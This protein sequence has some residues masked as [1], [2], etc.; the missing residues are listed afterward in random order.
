MLHCTKLAEK[1]CTIRC[2]EEKQIWCK[3][4]VIMGW[5]TKW[6]ALTLQG[7]PTLWLKFTK[8]CQFQMVY[9]H[10]VQN[11]SHCSVAHCAHACVL[12]LMPPFCHSVWFWSCPDRFTGMLGTWWELSDSM[13]LTSTPSPHCQCVNGSQPHDQPWCVLEVDFDHVCVWAWGDQA[14]QVAFSCDT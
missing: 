6:G 12:H 5:S 8:N 10:L 1:Y 2:N 3:Q 7:R 14:L 4:C 9:R 11:L 13:L